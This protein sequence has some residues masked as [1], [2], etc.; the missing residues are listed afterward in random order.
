MLKRCS[1]FPFTFSYAVFSKNFNFNFPMLKFTQK[2]IYCT[3]INT[4][5][6]STIRTKVSRLFTFTL[7]DILF[8][9]GGCLCAAI[10]FPREVSQVLPDWFREKNYFFNDFVP[11]G[12]VLKSRDKEC[13]KNTVLWSVALCCSTAIFPH[14]NS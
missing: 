6:T 5:H 2:P 12:N 8:Q 14:L 7:A 4:P 9:H 3:Y 11:M 1:H 13:W 10:T